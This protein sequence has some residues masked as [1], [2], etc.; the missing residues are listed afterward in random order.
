LAYVKLT[1]LF[2]NQDQNLWMKN[3]KIIN[4]ISV[5]GMQGM[6]SVQNSDYSASKAALTSFFDSL[7]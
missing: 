3:Q 1:K 2:L 5:A 4:L 6:T 7:R